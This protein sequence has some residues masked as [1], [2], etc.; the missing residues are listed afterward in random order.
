MIG[1]VKAYTTRVGGGPFPSECLDSDVGRTLQEVGKEIGV[2]T[3]RNRRCGWLDLVILRY[4]AEINHYT[5]SYHSRS[6]LTCAEIIQ[7]PRHI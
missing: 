1:V 6:R 5:V 2:S 4:S 3:G 7:I